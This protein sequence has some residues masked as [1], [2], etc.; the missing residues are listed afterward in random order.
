MSP[1]PMR[2]AYQGQAGAYSEQAARRLCGREASLLPCETL[3]DVFAAVAAGGAQCAV[4]PIENTLTGAVPGVVTMLLS[5]GLNVHGATIERIDHVLAAPAGQALE[6]IREVLSHPVALAQCTIFFRAHPTMRPVPVFDTA[7]A[8]EMVMREGPSGRAAI[9]GHS[10]AALYGAAILAEHLQDH[11]DNF[12][13]F[14]RVAPAPLPALH[15]PAHVIIGARLPHRPGA[16]A[17]LLQDLAQTGINLTRID[18]APLHGSPFEYEFLIEGLLPESRRTD[19][20]LL[21]W[22]GEA[23]LRIIGLFPAEGPQPAHP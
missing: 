13:R 7:G 9:A 20:D 4:V 22:Q 16:L 8:L 11:P 12:T 2:V 6:G 5:S 18:S 21:T 23:E 17:R 15:G 1:E 10:A 3:S 19:A 14:V